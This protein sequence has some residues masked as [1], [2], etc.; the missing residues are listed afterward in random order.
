MGK[1][2]NLGSLV[3]IVMLLLIA[4]PAAANKGGR[5]CQLLCHRR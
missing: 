1:Q 2:A 5:A 3:L 4:G